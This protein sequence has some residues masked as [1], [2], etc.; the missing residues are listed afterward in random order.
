MNGLNQE[1]NSKNQRN[2]K[3]KCLIR[4]IPIYI[5]DFI[6]IALP[7][8]RQ[9]YRDLIFRIFLSRQLAGLSFGSWFLIIQPFDKISYFVH[10]GTQLYAIVFENIELAQKFFNEHS[11]DKILKDYNAGYSQSK[12]AT[13][14]EQS[15][16]G[17]LNVIGD[18]KNTGISLY[19]TKDVKSNFV[20]VIKQ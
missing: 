11:D 15:V 2:S 4:S 18:I 19:Q 12:K 1:P 9:G 16:D 5:S 6:P 7:T 17:I 3:S 14:Q 13:G 10:A 8:V 20:K